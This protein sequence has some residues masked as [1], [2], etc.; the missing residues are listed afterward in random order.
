M[1]CSTYVVAALAEIPIA[2]SGEFHAADLIFVAPLLLVVLVGVVAMV[3]G[4]RSDSE[5]PGENRESTGTA[6]GPDDSTT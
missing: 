4:A 2:H 1:Q 6:R 3:R 5:E